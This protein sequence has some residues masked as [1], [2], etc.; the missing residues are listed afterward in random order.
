MGRLSWPELC[1][2]EV[3]RH[4]LNVALSCAAMALLPVAQIATADA[5]PAKASSAAR[6]IPILTGVVDAKSV[7]RFLSAVS[8]ST[9]KIIGIKV[10]VERSR[11]SDA[12]YYVG[13]SDGQLVISGGDPFDAPVELV[14]NGNTGSTMDML[15]VDG[16]Y[17]IKIGGTHAAGAVSFGAMPVDEAILRLRRGV[18]FTEKKF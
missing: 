10:A 13:Q 5:K 1:K 12:Q 3:M 14:V 9:D 4:R 17:L 7:Q 6:V 2:G 11:D 8:R 18:R 16:F 15:T